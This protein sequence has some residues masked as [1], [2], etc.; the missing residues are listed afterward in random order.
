M[1][2]A[3]ASLYENVSYCVGLNGFKTDWFTVTCGLKQGCNLSTILFN[4]Y[5]IDVVEKIKATGKGIDIGEEKV[6][7]LLYADDLIRLAPSASDLQVML[8][9]LHVWCD[10]NKI[11]ISEEKSNV[12]HF[13]PYSVNS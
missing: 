4:F 9:E 1:Y 13:K 10:E 5:I 8:D 2:N 7:V 3:L 6:S 12:I 11:T